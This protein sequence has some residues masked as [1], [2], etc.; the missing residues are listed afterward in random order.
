MNTKEMTASL[1]RDFL[2]SHPPSWLI[3]WVMVLFLLFNGIPQ[4]PVATITNYTERRVRNIRNH[5]Y[6]GQDIPLSHLGIFAEKEC[7][8]FHLSKKRD[9]FIFK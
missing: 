3:R 6:L 2:E 8:E 9:I 4:K 1:V 5:F 7:C